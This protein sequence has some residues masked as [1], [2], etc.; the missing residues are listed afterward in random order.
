M[1]DEQQTTN[2]QTNGMAVTSLVL[3]ILGIVLNLIFILPY[4]LGAMAII[5]GFIGTKNSNG[6][7]MAVAGIILGAIT[8]LLKFLFWMIVIVLGSM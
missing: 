8:L 5:F 2:P 6:K 7:S 4:F 1:L 3:G